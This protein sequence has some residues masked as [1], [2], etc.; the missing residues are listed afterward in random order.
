MFA[1][2]VSRRRF[3]LGEPHSILSLGSSFRLFETPAERSGVLIVA[4]LGI[5][6]GGRR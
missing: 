2:L 3:L 1:G 6:G 5:S 4:A